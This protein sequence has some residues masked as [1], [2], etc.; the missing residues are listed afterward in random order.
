MAATIHAGPAGPAGAV[1]DGTVL[2]L[3]RALRVLSV[4]LGAGL[5]LLV[6]GSALAFGAVH[7][8]AR[9]P[10]FELTAVLA[11]L[12]AARTLAVVLLR[13]RLGRS[14]FAFHASG[15][16]VM[17]DVEEPYGIRTWSFDLD[18]P[19]VPSVPL[20]LPGLVFALWVVVQMVPLPPTLADALAGAETLPG[21]EK[22][23]GWR[24]LSVSVAQTAT[25]LFFLAWALVVHVVAST[26][27]GGRESERRFRRFVSI[28][29]LVLAIVGLAQMATGTHRVYWFFKPWEGAGEHIFGPFVDRDHFAFYMLMVTPIAF[30]L[31]AH[32]YRRYRARVG[33]R[34][35][36]RRWL[37]TLSRPEGLATLYATVPALAA[38][39]SLIATTSRGALIA[40]TGGL[41]LAALSLWR[42]RAVPV[43]A[44]AAVFTLVALSWFGTDRIESRM[45]RVAED[46]PGRT[47][48]WHDTLDRM[49]GR[50]I[51]GSG[52]NTFDVAMYRASAWALPAG[53]TPW[54]DPYETTIVGVARVG[55]RTPEAIPGLWWYR[56]A[57]NDYVQLLTETGTVGLLLALWA[58]ARVLSSVRAD[59]WLLAAAAAVFM[60]EFVDFGLHLPAIVALFM[61]LAAIRPSEGG[62]GSR[63]VPAG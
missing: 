20:L 3:A 51:G 54:S 7:P 36:R 49:G 45:R 33:Q 61:C 59:P 21:A 19:L 57:H 1:S 8:W 60:H 62:G 10:L 26:I 53:A 35:N 13:R 52:F 37:V 5:A 11:V 15:R 32:A 25:G 39:G 48:I 41:A 44:F 34:A 50:W 9:A 16:W 46:S 29:G 24:T 58:A 55:F 17:L 42:R 27:L 4:L 31:F 40:F 6:A 2:S 23:T 12:A 47:V 28:L 14:R 18:R 22:A 43:W 30:G 38:V 63:T 56:E